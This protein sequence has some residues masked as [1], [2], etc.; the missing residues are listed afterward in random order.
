MEINDEK[1]TLIYKDIILE[2]INDF[3]ENIQNLFGYIDFFSNINH[4]IYEQLSSN[5]E[6]LSFILKYTDKLISSFLSEKLEEENTYKM[7]IINNKTRLRNF[8]YIIKLFMHKNI[9]YKNSKEL[10]QKILDK[11]FIIFNY[12]LLKYTLIAKKNYAYYK[13]NKYIELINYLLKIILYCV[14]IAYFSNIIN[15]DIFSSIIKFVISLSLSKRIDRSPIKNEDEI[16]NMMFLSSCIDLIKLV[17][18]KLCEIQNEYTQKQEELFN[19]IILYINEDLLD[20]N[21]QN[22][23]INYIN[24]IFLSKNDYKTTFLI[25]FSTII[26]NIKSQ[27]VKNN[28]FNLLTNIYSFSF[29]YKNGMTPT[30]QQ[31][32]PL[33]T[34]IDRKNLEQIKND[35]KA[36]DFT[37]NLIKSL[38][39]KEKE[40]LRYNSCMLRE[41]FYLGRKTSGI[42]FDFNSLD[43]DFMIIFG[44][45]IEPNTKENLMIFDII[46]T[47][48]NTSQFKCYLMKTQNINSYELFGHDSKTEMTTKISV[49]IGKTYIFAF[50]FKAPKGFFQSRNI[51]IKYIKDEENNIIENENNLLNTKVSSGKTLEIKNFK[52]ENLCMLF[53]CEIKQYNI[54]QLKVENNFKGFIGDIVILNMKNIKEKTDN[55]LEKILL[56]LKGNY[57][58]IFS[59]FSGNIKEYA[60]AYKNQININLNLLKEM[61]MKYDEN[62]NKLFNSIKFIMTPKYF[63]L[64]DYQDDI[65]YLNKNNYVHYLKQRD[66]MLQIKKKYLSVKPDPLEEDTIIKISSSLFDKKFH[67]FENESTLNRFIN[68]DGI[69]YLCLLFEYYYQILCRLNFENKNENVDNIQLIYSD[70]NQKILNILHF[71]N[72]NIIKY[73]IYLNN[74][75]EIYQFFYQ[76][77]ITLYKFMEKSILNIQTL[78]LLTD[79]LNTFNEFIKKNKE[80]PEKLKLFLNVRKNLF[81]FVL[82]PKLYQETDHSYFQKLNDTITNLLEIIDVS[83][84][85]YNNNYIEDLLQVEILDKILSF[86]WL[87][88]NKEYKNIFYDKVKEKYIIFLN[89]FLKLSFHKDKNRN[90][91]KPLPVKNTSEIKE[92]NKDNETP[93]NLNEAK[94]ILCESDKE[95]EFANEKLLI[96][97]YIDKVL[98][99]RKNYFI[100]SNMFHILIKTN[101]IKEIDK[102]KIKKIK[103]IIINEL[104]ENNDKNNDRNKVIILSCLEILIGFYFS[105]FQNNKNKLIINDILKTNKMEFD[106]FIKNLNLNLDL[107]YALIHS[108]NSIN[109]I[110]NN[111]ESN[112]NNIKGKSQRLSRISNNVGN[113]SND[114]LYKKK[115]SFSGIPF[116]DIIILNLNEIHS[117]FIKT[118]FEDII[119]LLYKY[120]NNNNDEKVIK[121]I[122]EKIKNNIDYIFKYPDSELYKYIFSSESEICA[123]FFYLKMKLE[124]NNGFNYIEKVITKYHNDLLRNHCSPFIFKFLLFFTNDN[125]LPF[126]SNNTEK[127]ALKLKNDLMKFIIETF[128]KMFKELN[129]IKDIN[130][131]IFINNLLNFIILINQELDYNSKNV[132]F[133]N[134]DLC[135]SLYKFIILIEKIGLLYSNYYIEVNE[136]YGK[137]ISEV[138]YDL[139]FSFSEKTFNENYFLKIFT[140]QNLKEQEIFTVFYLIDLLKEDILEKEKRVNEKL[141]QFIPQ[142]KNLRYIHKNY[143]SSNK[144]SSLKLFL[145]KKLFA[146]KDVNFSIYFLAKS[147]IY[148][149]SNIMKGDKK[150]KPFLTDTFLPILSNNILLLYTKRNNFYGNKR[151][152]IFPL[153]TYTK[154]F[155]ESYIVQNNIFDLYQNFF[156]K[157]MKVNLKAEYNICYCYSSR[158]IHDI[159]KNIIPNMIIE[160]RN[161]SEA[162]LNVVTSREIS[163]SMINIKE[164]NLPILSTK[165]NYT[166]SLRELCD[167]NLSDKSQDISSDY[168]EIPLIKE[169]NNLEYFSNFELIKKNR[170]IFK[171]KKLFFK[172][173]FSEIFKHI[174]FKDKIFEK[175]KLTYLIG[176]RDQ[177]TINIETKQL[178]YPTKQKNFSNFLEPKLFLTRDFNFYDDEFFPI[179]QKYVKR[180]VLDANIENIFLYR[181]EYKFNKENLKMLTCELVTNQF[182]Y[183]G[184]MYFLENYILFESSEDPRDNSNNADKYDIFAKF[185]LSSKN[186]DNKPKKT[187]FVLIFNDDIREIIK[188]R[189]LLTNQSLEIFISNGKSYFFNFFRINEVEKAYKYFNEINENLLKKNSN[190][191]IF[192]INN[193][194][195]IKEIVLSFK[196][197]KITTYEYLLYLNKYSTR[198]Y[199]DLSQYPVFPW[200][201]LKHE[202]LDEI[203]EAIDNNIN[204]IKI[205]KELCLRDLNYP[206]SLQTEEKRE[207]TIN[208]YLLEK[209]ESNFPFHLYKHYST[210]GY[211]YFYLMRL[212]PYAQNT[213]RFQNY[214]IECAERILNSFIEIEYILSEDSD[215]RELI[216]DFFCYFDF[217]FNLNCFN[218]GIKE[219]G[220]MIDDLK[221]DDIINSKYINKVSSY[222]LSLYRDRK[223]INSSIISKEIYK[224]VDIIFGKKQLPDQDDEAEKTCNIYGKMTYEQKINFEKKLNKYKKLIEEKKADVKDS[225]TKIKNKI[226]ISMNFG[227]TPKQILKESIIYSGENKL[228]YNQYKSHNSGSEKLLFFKNIPNNSFLLFKNFNK[229]GKNK[230]RIVLICDKNNLKPKENNIY[231]CKSLN[232]INKNKMFYLQIGEKKIKIPL[233]NPD[234]AFSYLFYQNDKISKSFVLVILSCRYFGNYFKVQTSS[235]TLNIFCEDF[236]T[237]IKGR[238]F[239]KG[240]NIFYTGLING[241]LIQWQVVC[242]LK[243]KTVK[244]IYSHNS[245]ITALEIYQKQKIIITSSEDKFIH[246]RKIVDFEL[247][248]VI[249]LT[250]SFGNPIISQSPNIFPSLIKVSE[251]NLLYVLF[252][253]YDLKTNVIRGYN[254]NGIFFAQT[255]Y[256]KFTNEK[257]INLIINNISFTKSFDL[258]VG[259]YNENKYTIL[260]SWGLSPLFPLKDIQISGNLHYGTKYFEYDYSL[261]LFYILYDNEFVI[262]NPKDKNDF[263]YLGIS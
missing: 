132:L 137:I 162:T 104:E 236:V 127:N 141:N 52:T 26:S 43:A 181:H 220:E 48:T 40:I 179:S 97:Y 93:L 79:I 86:N 125:I 239:T 19:S 263:K 130:N 224:W 208:K 254:L 117:F 160:S 61:L 47:K 217:L 22:N 103:Y 189:T 14:G 169:N 170:T 156:K 91:S 38:I 193:E 107:F 96:N 157:D 166:S 53:G 151:C 118:I 182:L 25:G 184:K 200:L 248:S 32:E 234:Y 64:I 106:D 233:Y 159:K 262:M 92:K 112:G 28:F 222:V 56:Q 211:I 100:F 194:D 3:N 213:I 20:A 187:K 23:R 126:E 223:L 195:D 258:V 246:I 82:S 110:F 72:E 8:N 80:D 212:N 250:S 50:N 128:L 59:L 27:D 121:E 44:I 199:N 134:V 109:T 155:F 214:K 108:I 81:D 114:F 255:D 153:Y 122:Y 90:N 94:I 131:K 185:A 203:I 207:D 241:K 180:K 244:S 230:T 62:E 116:V 176:R 256:T 65:D 216:P 41:G 164:E 45:K 74:R 77:A 87:L 149:N 101:L 58:E 6:I 253:D 192:K 66:R 24:K 165:A 146:I 129:Q 39:K 120:E 259:F 140:K 148:F 102:K 167:K 138:L 133:Q 168:D 123:E 218:L 75:Q 154:K 9:K 228:S 172:I 13:R 2:N 18:K 188:R 186:R 105:G 197:G 175:I 73:R 15:E 190:Q 163:M 33:F 215:N 49:Q 178:T 227:M 84:E 4:L 98:M 201:L 183:F 202:K 69:H 139:F 231:D 240:D 204:N 119:Y 54:E 46:N 76:M 219:N 16:F 42:I 136:N 36:S 30:I 95:I 232:L 247:L 177:K 226:D 5:K 161:I 205:E 210:T 35:I 209:T 83:P 115:Y 10:N 173:K 174:I 89:Q 21:S 70:I 124:G 229:K 238:N 71:F 12:N 257:D 191:F 261:G 145:N 135:E 51:R 243:I 206:I 37:L 251:L 67:I 143:F 152:K 31:L 260:Q 144:K 1:N 60:F 34:N 249:D 147:F 78:K 63:N 242:N 68:S 196:K 158:L 221:F 150:F 171:P 252:Y 235:K 88:D 55:E 237:C 111:R 85:E 99:Q 11:F 7:N 225:I 113:N 245:S 17:F 29:K 198:T 57:H 142:L